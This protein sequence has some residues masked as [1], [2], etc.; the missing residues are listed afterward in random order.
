MK[1]NLIFGLL[2]FTINLQGG[3]PEEYSQFQTWNYN[4]YTEYDD[5]GEEYPDLMQ[6]FKEYW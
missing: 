5:R 1:D 6:V 4:S 3:S 2:A